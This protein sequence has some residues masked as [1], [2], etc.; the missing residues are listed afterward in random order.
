MYR[1]SGQILKKA[2]KFIPGGSSAESGRVQTLFAAE[3][4]PAFFRQAQGS[5]VT[6]ADG[7][8]Y[9]D[10]GM[11]SGCSILGYNHPA[12]VEALDR[13]LKKGFVS[14]LPSVLEPRL[15]ELIVELFPSVEMV[16]F[17]RTDE[18]AYRAA[19]Q[20]ARVLTSRR[21]V[22]ASGASRWLDPQAGGPGL[23]EDMRTGGAEFRFNDPQHFLDRL[24]GL[25]ELPAAVVME[26]VVLAHPDLEFLR[27]IRETCLR[28]GIVL[29]WD[30]VETGARL[31]PGGAQEYYGF[32]P[33]LTVLGRAVASGMPLAAVGGRQKLMEGWKRLSIP[34]AS[35]PD[36]LGLASALAT[37]RFVRDNPVDDH[38]EKVGGRLLAGFE[39][40]ADVFPGLCRFAGIPHISAIGL[41][42]DIPGLEDI[43]PD[44]YQW[45]LRCG[46]IIPRRGNIYPSFA[47]TDDQVEDGLYALNQVFDRLQR[48]ID[49]D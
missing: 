14:S 24:Q 22:L 9:V 31:A 25:P 21:C 42:R 5:V 29:I 20:L 44:F 6:D 32:T 33:D 7:Q 2:K 16:R 45:L 30:E 10:F 47:H 41:R 46:L 15:A 18:E 1:K 8:A 43:E 36:S 49:R 39:K 19:V 26:P 34:A 4:G 11:G 28:F 17:L 35:A 48:A 12:V 13:E 3:T 38:I 23:P 37:L 40:I 27:L